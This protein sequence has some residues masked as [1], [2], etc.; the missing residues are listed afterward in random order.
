MD[1]HLIKA[2]GIYHGP[3]VNIDA[4]WISKINKIK[5]SLQIWKTRNLTFSGKTN[6]IKTI[7]LP[8]IIFVYYN[9][10]DVEFLLE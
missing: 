5:A 8:L 6:V 10:I 3:V 9:K 1:G 4:I 7:I 2:L